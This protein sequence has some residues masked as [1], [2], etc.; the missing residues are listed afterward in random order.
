MASVFTMATVRNDDKASTVLVVATW[1]KIACACLG[2]GLLT[3]LVVPVCLDVNESC[4]TTYTLQIMF[5]KISTP[6]KHL[7]I[8]GICHS[9]KH[10]VNAARCM[11]MYCSCQNK[12]FCPTLPY[13][14]LCQSCFSG[15]QCNKLGQ[16]EYLQQWALKMRSEIKIH[17]K[18]KITHIEIMYTWGL[19]KKKIAIMSI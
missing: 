15:M 2:F 7:R 6:W 14:W 10:K 11:L 17:Q 3:P 16:T 1:P 5:S 9:N 19:E 4:D 8:Q 18:I 13:L 12:A